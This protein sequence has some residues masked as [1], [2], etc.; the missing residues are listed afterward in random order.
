[1]STKNNHVTPGEVDLTHT[2]LQHI[3]IGTVTSGP[4]YSNAQVTITGTHPDYV[5]N[6]VVP[7]G[8]QG[9]TGA[10]GATG[11]TGPQG[12]QGAQ[13]ARGATGATGPQGP[14]AT[15]HGGG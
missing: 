1:M 13:G 7:Q 12:P 14:S 8:D 11:A 2:A 3:T 10:K 15:C 5:V 4:P 6:I 9:P